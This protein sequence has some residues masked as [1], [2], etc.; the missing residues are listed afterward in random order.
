MESLNNFQDAVSA[1]LEMGEDPCKEDEVKCIRL[2][3]PE[4]KK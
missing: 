4:N 2:L 1:L 3:R